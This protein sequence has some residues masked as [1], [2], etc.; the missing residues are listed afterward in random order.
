MASLNTTI[1]GEQQIWVYK[2][3]I[4]ELADTLFADGSQHD[5]TTAAQLIEAS[6]ASIIA[7]TPHEGR[8]ESEDLNQTTAEADELKLIKKVVSSQEITIAAL[9]AHIDSLKEQ[10]D[11]A[12]NSDKVQSK[13]PAQMTR[14]RYPY[15]FD[16]GRTYNEANLNPTFMRDTEKLLVRL[17]GVSA[18]MAADV[19]VIREAFNK[20]DD[21]NFSDWSTEQWQKF[22]GS[23]TFWESFLLPMEVAVL[24]IRAHQSKPEKK[25]GTTKLDNYERTLWDRLQANGGYLTEAEIRQAQEACKL[26]HA[27]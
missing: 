1:E 11:R 18:P 21:A 19:Q 25:L 8:E 4:I 26:F 14:A 7:P 17:A 13:S 27:G 2:S 12:Q 24:K 20:L 5:P 6:L 22:P 23:Q 10:L 9:Q 15:A 3:K 16:I